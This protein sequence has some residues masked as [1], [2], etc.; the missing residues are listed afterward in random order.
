VGVVDDELELEMV[1]ELDTE[2]VEGL[3]VEDAS[4]F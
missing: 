3:G 1:E 2:D 4:A